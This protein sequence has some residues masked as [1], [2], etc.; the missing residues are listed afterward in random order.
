MRGPRHKGSRIETGAKSARVPFRREIASVQKEYERVISAV[1]R[2]DPTRVRITACHLM[3]AWLRMEA[4]YIRFI[5][6]TP[7]G[8]R[9]DRS[10]QERSVLSASNSIARD[11]L[12]R[13]LAEMFHWNTSPHEFRVLREVLCWLHEYLGMFSIVGFPDLDHPHAL[14]FSPPSAGSRDRS[15]RNRAHRSARKR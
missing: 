4:A 7:A 10:R 6:R 2:S 5:E 12:R 15:S 13:A 8:L 3:R 9:Q 14:P 1:G 11:L